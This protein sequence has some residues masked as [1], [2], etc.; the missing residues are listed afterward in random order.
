MVERELEKGE[1]FCPFAFTPSS[2]IRESSVKVRRAPAF[3]RKWLKSCAL[4][5]GVKGE[6]KKRKFGECVHARGRDESFT[7]CVHARRAKAGAFLDLAG[8]KRAKVRRCFVFPRV[9][10]SFNRSVSRGVGRWEEIGVR[11]GNRFALWSM[12]CGCSEYS[13][14]RRKHSAQRFTMALRAVSLQFVRFYAFS[15]LRRESPRVLLWVMRICEISRRFPFLIACKWRAYSMNC[16]I[17]IWC[18][19]EN[20]LIL[21]SEKPHPVCGFLF[22]FLVL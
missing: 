10:L 13:A 16:D 20:I 9:L 21:P 15:R 2:P 1:G 4:W 17:Q 14:V 3:T 11:D 5:L 7:R 6:G 8:E 18:F 22:H 12:G 19:L